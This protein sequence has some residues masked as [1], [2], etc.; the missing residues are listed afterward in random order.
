[1]VLFEGAL[2]AS[3]TRWPLRGREKTQTGVYIPQLQPVL[4]LSRVRVRRTGTCPRVLHQHDLQ[5]PL[6]S[7]VIPLHPAP[8]PQ[9]RS[10]SAQ[11]MP[12]PMHCSYL[13][14][15]LVC[16]FH[17]PLR[18]AASPAGQ[19]VATRLLAV[20]S[21]RGQRGFK[22]AAAAARPPLAPATRRSCLR[23]TTFAL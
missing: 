3:V 11:T 7:L 21:R 14:L 22:S 8:N 2:V 4:G 9:A 12:M 20:S 23:T 15:L 18:A 19:T 10:C 17:A 1:M 5:P 13:Y 6:G 16:C